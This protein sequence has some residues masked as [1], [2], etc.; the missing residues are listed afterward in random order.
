[1]IDSIIISDEW[2]NSPRHVLLLHVLLQGHLRCLETTFGSLES[3]KSVL[4]ILGGSVH[5]S[6]HSCDVLSQQM[7][8]LHQLL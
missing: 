6:S 5:S 3:H 1:M 4:S 2:I 7:V 8:E